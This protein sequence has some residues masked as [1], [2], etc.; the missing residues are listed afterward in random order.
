MI[1]L[2][3]TV[4]SNFFKFIF[5]GPFSINAINKSLRVAKMFISFA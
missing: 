3:N 1:Q 4:I 5:R 2:F